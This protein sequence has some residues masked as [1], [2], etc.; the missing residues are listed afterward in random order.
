MHLIKKHTLRDRIPVKQ[1]SVCLVGLEL[2]RRVRALSYTMWKTSGPMQEVSS[3]R[4]ESLS[5]VT[6]SMVSGCPGHSM[7]LTHY[8][9]TCAAEAVLHGLW[10]VGGL[11]ARCESA[12]CVGVSWRKDARVQLH[13][14]KIMFYCIPGRGGMAQFCPISR[15]CETQVEA[16]LKSRCY[17]P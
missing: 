5:R 15:I 2:E 11:C 10:T 13:L 7:S 6:K 3:T 4:V 9:C 16:E 12:L 14:P 17:L 8:M 1:L